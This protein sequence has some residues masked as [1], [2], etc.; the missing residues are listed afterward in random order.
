MIYFGKELV[1]SERRFAVVR[2]GY[3][4]LCCMVGEPTSALG[5]TKT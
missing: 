3:A 2:A 5:A 1:E 4:A